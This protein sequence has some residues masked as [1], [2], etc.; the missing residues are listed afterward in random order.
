VFESAGPLTS[1]LN[2]S[3]NSSRQSSITQFISKSISLIK[4]KAVELQI[5]KFI[6]KHFHLFTIVEET[7]FR[8]LIKMLAPNYTMPSRKTISNSLLLQMYESTLE[9]VKADLNDVT[10]LSLTTDDWTSINN[11]HF[12][13]L[14][15]HF[16]NSDTVLC[17]RLIGCINY[18]EK[19][20]SE[21][22]AN[23]LMSTAK[24]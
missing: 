3:T 12:I 22:L 9:K 23:F 11:E 16:I 21:E 4:S 2:P 1:S 24:K 6:L 5:T 14:T 17:L 8:N 13:A 15:V 7:E 20:T 18:N 10:A 19:C